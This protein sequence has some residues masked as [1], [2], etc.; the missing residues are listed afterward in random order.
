M[1]DDSGVV[2]VV[3]AGVMGASLAQALTARGVATVLQDADPAALQEAAHRIAAGDR[4]ARL[5]AGGSGGPAD[6]PGRLSYVTATEELAHCALVIENVTED[7]RVK[8]AL[9][10]RLDRILDPGAVV[11]VNTS[12]IAVSGLALVTGHP[13]RVVGAH[14]MNPVATSSMVE[15]IRTPYTAQWALDRLGALVRRLGKDSVV[16]ADATGFV[17]NRCLMMFINEAA[18]VLDDDVASPQQVDRLFRGC[19][20]HRTGPLRTA[21]IIGIDTIVHT[22][23]VLT[24]AYGPERFTPSARL[25]RMVRDGHLG[26]KTGRGFYIYAG[27]AS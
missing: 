5:T 21:D 12:A 4:L 3:G 17:I 2:G 13:E 16:V 25:L 11:A 10:D 6:G 8:E 20:G 15:V 1:A 14:F 27:E 23:R 7:A 26:R 18:A 24:D 19:V 22:L 9:H